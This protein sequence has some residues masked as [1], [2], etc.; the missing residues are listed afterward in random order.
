[1]TNNKELFMKWT[2]Y[3][4]Y[5]QCALL[6]VAL[7]T[8]LPFVG[9]WFNWGLRIISIATIFILYKLSP[10]NSRYLKSAIFMIV[11]LLTT[12]FLKGLGLLAIVGMICSIIATY[13]EYTGHSEMMAE[14]DEKLSKNWRSLFNWNFW[15]AFLV[16]FIAAGIALAIGIAES[17]SVDFAAGVTE[18]ITD[19]YDIILNVVYLILMKRMLKVYAGYEPQ[20]EKEVANEISD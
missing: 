20:V 4:F 11:T 8:K 9:S 5:V 6:V 12:I 10:L 14:V 17:S 3:L 16:S 1:M 18:V 7:I 2:Q 13:Q 15:G 19:G